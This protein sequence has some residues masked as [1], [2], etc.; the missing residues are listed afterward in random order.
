MASIKP[1]NPNSVLIYWKQFIRKK[2]REKAFVNVRKRTYLAIRK[3]QRDTKFFVYFRLRRKLLANGF[4]LSSQGRMK[5]FGNYYFKFWFDAFLISS[6]S[7]SS[8]S[9]YRNEKKK[10]KHFP[11]TI[12]NHSQLKLL[13]SKLFS[14]TLPL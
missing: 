5:W 14:F 9:Y 6:T 1:L 13:V 7:F 4:Y 3:P 8:F 10:S 2:N 11:E 12:L